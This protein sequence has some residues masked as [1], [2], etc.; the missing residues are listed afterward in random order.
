MGDKVFLTVRVDIVACLKGYVT[1]RGDSGE[2][3][4]ANL[5]KFRLHCSTGDA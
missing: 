1:G 4:V 5:P 3:G 2:N